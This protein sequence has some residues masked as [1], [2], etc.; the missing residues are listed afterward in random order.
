MWPLLLSTAVVA[1]FHASQLCPVYNL[2]RWSAGVL[3]QPL[4]G[5]P[6]DCPAL[7]AA[8]CYQF[9]CTCQFHGWRCSPSHTLHT[10]GL[11]SP[12][13]HRPCMHIVALLAVVISALAL[14]QAVAGVIEHA[15]AAVAWQLGMQSGVLR[16]TGSVEVGLCCILP[17]CMPLEQSSFHHRCCC[18]SCSMV[19]WVFPF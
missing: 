8:W 10:C 5:Q 13:L 15:L 12:L 3:Y 16:V 17:P 11:H 1:C 6:P 7:C 19:E 2:A 9:T 4:P 14:E 18:E